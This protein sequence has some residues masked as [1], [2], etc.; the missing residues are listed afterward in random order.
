MFSALMPWEEME[1]TCA[2]QFSPP[3]GAPAKPVRL[4]F[5]ALFIKALDYP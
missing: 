4:V 2:N 5:G 1:A 3:V